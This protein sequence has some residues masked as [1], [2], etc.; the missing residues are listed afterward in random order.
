MS[1]HNRK[2]D[3]L[4]AIEVSLTSEVGLKTSEFNIDIEDKW[5]SGFHRITAKVQVMVSGHSIRQEEMRED[6]INV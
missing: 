1:L 4:K 3:I 5:E 2:M 6:K